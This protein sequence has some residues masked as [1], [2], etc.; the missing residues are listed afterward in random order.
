MDEDIL[1]EGVERKHPFCVVSK[2]TFGDYNVRDIQLNTAW[3]KN[4]YGIDYAVVPDDM[5]D[6]ILATCGFFDIELSDDETRVVGFTPLDKPEIPEEV[7]EPTATDDIQ[8]MLID[9]EYRLTL[10][11][12]GLI[13]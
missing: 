1:I 3:N 11:E 7:E 5:V 8:S 6:D 10:L 13:E 12:L 9:Q 4:P 2:K